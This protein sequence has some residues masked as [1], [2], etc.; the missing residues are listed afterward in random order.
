MSN[1]ASSPGFVSYAEPHEVRC[2]IRLEAAL[3]SRQGRKTCC[4]ARSLCESPAQP[5]PSR[6]LEARQASALL[7]A[8]SSEQ[9]G[10]ALQTRPHSS[11]SNKVRLHSG[12]TQRCNEVAKAT[13]LAAYG[14][15]GGTD[16]SLE[17]SAPR[18]LP[19]AACTAPSRRVS[20]MRAN[21]KGHKA[22]ASQ[23]RSQDN[24]CA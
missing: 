9:P 24:L 22:L 4:K 6:T 16:P 18:L 15:S 13:I 14:K 19:R 1:S 17:I 10:G 7:P 5:L 11:N 3:V 8:T 2:K 12:C 21:T 20:K 23:C